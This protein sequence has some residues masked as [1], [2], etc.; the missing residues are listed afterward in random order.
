VDLEEELEDPPKADPVGRSDAYFADALALVR[1]VVLVAHDRILD[2]ELRGR[3]ADQP[4]IELRGALPLVDP[5]VRENARLRR[6]S[7]ALTVPGKEMTLV[8]GSPGDARQVEE[9]VEEEIPE[10]T[11]RDTEARDQH[12][13]RPF[14]EELPPAEPR[15]SHAGLWSSRLPSCSAGCMSFPC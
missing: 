2:L 7:L 9:V 8:D 1:H 14:D 11:Q 12:I 10:P 5:V 6:D 4:R 3:G 15:T 13:E